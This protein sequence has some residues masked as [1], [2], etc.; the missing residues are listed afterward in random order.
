MR[1][2]VQYIFSIFRSNRIQRIL[3]NVFAIRNF[4][5]KKIKPF[6]YS[7]E[8]QFYNKNLASKLHKN[9]L[10]FHFS[11]RRQQF[12]FIFKKC[13]RHANKIKLFKIQHRSLLYKFNLNS[14]SLT[15]S[16]ECL[17]TKIKSMYICSQKF[18]ELS[19][20]LFFLILII[21]RNPFIRKY[22]RKRIMTFFEKY[23]RNNNATY[24]GPRK[25]QNREIS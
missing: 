15:K 17:L 11:I 1:C 2:F 23:L 14:L 6:L 19:I 8:I 4:L 10:I 21:P 12:D 25:W 16:F 24:K 20:I 18:K 5:L 22:L 13:S 3:R 7:I 9:D